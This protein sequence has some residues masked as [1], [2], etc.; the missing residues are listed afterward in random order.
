MTGFTMDITDFDFWQGSSI[1]QLGH[2]V[3]I[4]P[5]S[6]QCCFWLHFLDFNETWYT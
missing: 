6:V 4:Q 5:I 1:F 2:S 3:W